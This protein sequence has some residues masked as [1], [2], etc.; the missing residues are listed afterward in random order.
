M[1]AGPEGKAEIKST[2]TY[3]LIGCIFVFASSLVVS[4]VLNVSK[5]VGIGKKISTKEVIVAQQSYI[6]NI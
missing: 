5:D 1:F 6:D 4:F 3:V 2:L